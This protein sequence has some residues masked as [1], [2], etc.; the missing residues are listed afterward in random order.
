MKPDSV[1]FLVFVSSSL[2]NEIEG[3]KHSFYFQSCVKMKPTLELFDPLVV[4]GHEH[5]S[6]SLSISLK[7]ETNLPPLESSLTM[8]RVLEPSFPLPSENIPINNY[9]PK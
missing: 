7:N 1:K 5:S 2:Q 3:L 6:S 8:D 9:M 4:P